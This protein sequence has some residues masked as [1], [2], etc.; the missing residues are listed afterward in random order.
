[1]TASPTPADAIIGRSA[2]KPVTLG[3]ERDGNLRQVG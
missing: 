1:L 3:V 2:G